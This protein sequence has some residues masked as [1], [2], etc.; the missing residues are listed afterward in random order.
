MTVQRHDSENRLEE[1]ARR[2]GADEAAGIDP[3]K[4]AWAVTAR[5]RREPGRR[6]WW[7]KGR[8]VPLAAAASLL[9][10]LGLVG[11]ELLRSHSAD[12]MPVPAE[13]AELQ[14]EQLQEVLD[15]LSEEA[16]VSDL[17]PI[18]LYQLDESELTALLQ[19]M[20]G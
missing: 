19:A 8:V 20:E 1:L 17:V 18:A 5:L 3:Q 15:S 14:D 4:V 12:T 6:S 7:P 10:V 2:L 16:P 9:V 13:F 11:R